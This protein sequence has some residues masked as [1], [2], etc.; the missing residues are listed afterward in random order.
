MWVIFDGI[1]VAQWSLVNIL[2]V[3]LQK[4]KLIYSFKNKQT[5]TENIKIWVFTDSYKFLV[6]YGVF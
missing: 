5:W 1:I 4:V 2:I 6:F 3:P